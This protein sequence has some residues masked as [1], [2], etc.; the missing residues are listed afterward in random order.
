[1]SGSLKLEGFAEIDRKWAALEAA[2]EDERTIGAMLM[3][4][5]QPTVAAARAIVGTGSVEWRETKLTAGDI[6]VEIDKE[7]S[8]GAT[9]AVSVGA[10]QRGWILRFVEF[11]TSENPAFPVMRPAWDQTRSAV[12]AAAVAGLKVITFRALSK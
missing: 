3:A 6:H 8:I 11:G 9:V 4:A 12:T 10:G 5:A 1:M 2:L 7:R